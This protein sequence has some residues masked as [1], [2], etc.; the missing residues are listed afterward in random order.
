MRYIDTVT[1]DEPILF[2][3]LHEG[4]RRANSVAIRTGFL[5]RPA[6]DAIAHPMTDFLERGG[7][8]LIVA[9]GAPIQADVDALTHLAALIRPHPRATLR[10]VLHPEEFQNAKT[11]HLRYSGGQTQALVG[12]ANLTLGGLESNHEAVILLDSQ[13]DGEAEIIASILEGIEAFRNRAGALPMSEEIRGLLS[14]RQ[15]ARKILSHKTFSPLQP[16]QRW[17]ELLQPA[18]DTIDKTASAGLM[19]IPTGFRYLDEIVGGWTPGSLTAIGSRPGLGRTSL[20]LTSV[21]HAAISTNNP[22][23]LFSVDSTA[24]DVTSHILCAEASIDRNSMR[25]GRMSNEDWT[26][27]A[28]RMSA[29][30]EAPL[31]VNASPGAGL[32]DLCDH[33]ANLARTEGLQLIAIDSMNSINANLHPDSGRERELSTI[34]RR[35]KQLALELDIPIL[36]TADIGRNPEMRTD[37]RP[38]LGDFHSSDVLAQV[39]DTVL[40]LHR[41]DAYDRDDPRSGETDIIVAKQR[42]GPTATLPIRHELRFGRFLDV[43]IGR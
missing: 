16:T 25:N 29:I 18:M 22:T 30:S 10:V 6:V 35:L 33:I 7:D 4:F 23:A 5:T 43:E 38:T 17:E 27:M 40:L 37:K 19:G 24:F 11:Y 20:L 1:G 31:W 13:T 36:V 26:E 14:H 2:E 28:K 41:P 12:S 15:N 9:G 42:G 32:S 39:A 3:W 21:R 8:L 34:G